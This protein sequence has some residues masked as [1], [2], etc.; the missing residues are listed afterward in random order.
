MSLY[1]LNFPYCQKYYRRC[2]D[3]FKANVKPELFIFYLHISICDWSQGGRK[4]E[5]ELSLFSSNFNFSEIGCKL[6]SANLTLVKL[7][8]YK[9]SS[10]R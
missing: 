5:C 9:T 7:P 2:N 6:S 1:L 4:P 10:Q 8:C 3:I